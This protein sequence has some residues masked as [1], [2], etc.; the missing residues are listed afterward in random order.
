V[1]VAVVEAAE[2]RVLVAVVV[3]DVILKV[4]PC[5]QSDNGITI[6]RVGWTAVGAHGIVRSKVL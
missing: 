4:A 1:E 3:G 2:A 6:F 5:F